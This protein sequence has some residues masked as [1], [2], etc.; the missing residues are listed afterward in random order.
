MTRTQIILYY[1]LAINLLAFIAYGNRLLF[2]AKVH[3]F[4]CKYDQIQKFMYFC[5]VKYLCFNNNTEQ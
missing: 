4:P 1:L 3:I 5:K 2:A